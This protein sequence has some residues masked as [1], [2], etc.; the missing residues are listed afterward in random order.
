M[1]LATEDVCRQEF[2]NLKFRKTPTRYII[3]KIEKEK[4][5]SIGFSLGN[6]EDRWQGLDLG[7]LRKFLSRQPV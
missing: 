5:V 1:N 6:W 2:D 4:I 3:Y 7:V